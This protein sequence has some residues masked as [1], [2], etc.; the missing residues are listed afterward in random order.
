MLV[1]LT[2]DPAR[3]SRLR[4]SPE[5]IP[6]FVDE[7][8]RL[9]A[10][11]VGTFRIVVQPCEVGGTALVPGS[12]VLVLLSSANHDAA[13]LPDTVAVRAAGLTFGHGIHYCLGAPLA[14][15]EARITLEELVSRFDH[16]ERRTDELT[17]TPQLIPRGV[18]T[19][20]LRF[21]PA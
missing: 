7:T 10:P 11:V 12:L 5:D 15:M 1:R 9:E 2:E 13:H 16:V 17:W 14:R 8:L 4:K 18:T 3:W 21:T 20:P 6:A 19:L